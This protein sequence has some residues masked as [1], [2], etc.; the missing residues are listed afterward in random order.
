MKPALRFRADRRDG[1]I[2][3]LVCGA[4]IAAHSLAWAS[5]V[6]FGAEP[7]HAHSA[8]GIAAIE[9]EPGATGPQFSATCIALVSPDGVAAGVA[10]ALGAPPVTGTGAARVVYLEF[11]GAASLDLSGTP[12]ASFDSDATITIPSFEQSLRNIANEPDNAGTA[13]DIPVSQLS[14]LAN[15]WR[16]EVVARV[17]AD[18]APF[19]VRVTDNLTTA[20]QANGGNFERVYIGGSVAMFDNAGTNISTTT[21]GT[22]ELDLGRANLNSIGFVFVEHFDEFFSNT[23]LAGELIGI[24]T[25]HEAGHEH[26]LRHVENQRARMNSRTRMNSAEL[27]ETWRAGA[28][29]NSSTLYQDSSLLLAQRLDLSGALIPADPTPDDWGDNYFA[30]SLITDPTTTS[31]LIVSGTLELPGDVDVFTFTAAQAVKLSVTVEPTAG[32]DA[33]LGILDVNGSNVVMSD[34][35]GS[36][37]DEFA[38]LITVVGHTYFVYVNAKTGDG[39]G[40]YQ[41]IMSDQAQPVLCSFD[42]DGDGGVGTGDF[43]VFSACWQKSVSAS[44]ECAQADFDG[45]ATVGSGDFGCLA[46]NW[47]LPCEQVSACSGVAGTEVA[48]DEMRVELRLLALPASS[49]L[50][51]TARLPESSS[52]VAPGSRFVLELWVAD[53]ADAVMPLACVFVDAVFDPPNIRLTDEPAIGKALPWF[54]DPY[55]TLIAGRLGN[56]GGCIAL[57]AQPKNEPESGW[58]LVAR[59]PVIAGVDTGPLV[60]ALEPTSTF[61]LTIARVGSGTVDPSNVHFGQVA[62]VTAAAGDLDADGDVDL[63]DYITFQACISAPDSAPSDACTDADFDADGDV[64]LADLLAFQSALTG[65]N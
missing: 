6:S 30:A 58:G 22:A 44:P 57:D 40:A 10:A 3:R 43:G 8:D 38:T 34:T 50:E 2:G 12:F 35:G 16:A 39:T 60:I 52:R 13:W 17:A 4:L 19:H 14:T 51:R 23:S 1:A 65:S 27:A 59:I 49:G 20:M 56:L 37:A 48:E 9:A 18:Y 42:L 7:T 25:A 21:L 29:Q 32:V 54:R 28:V 36:G 15:T 24:V 55:D 46:A 41:L 45:D 26:G 47:L 61:G 62:L 33:V 64:D 31:P 53:R 5:A 63:S 11:D